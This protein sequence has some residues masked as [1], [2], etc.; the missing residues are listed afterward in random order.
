[1]QERKFDNLYNGLEKIEAIGTI[2]S[3]RK[4]TKYKAS[5]TIN[6]ESINSNKKYRGTN[7]IV[8]LQK[9]EKLEYGDKV[10]I[11][12]TFERAKTARNYKEFDYR[13]YL[14]SKNIFG[15]VDV[16]HS[17]IIKQNNLNIFKIGINNLRNQIKDNLSTILGEEASLTIRNSSSEIHQKFLMKLYKILETVA[18]IIFW[19]Y[20]ARTSGFII[21][22]IATTLNSINVS[23]RKI[24]II[25]AIFL[26]IFMALTGFTPSVVRACIMSIIVIMAR[27]LLQEK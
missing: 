25:T 12:G 1:M 26:L 11:N 10:K 6:V 19:L 17:E 21:I 5:Y 7:L 2:I 16:E 15:V 13:E 14:K 4:D 20:L 22:G 3:E 18:Y 9:S 8:Y 24:R 23:K 27:N